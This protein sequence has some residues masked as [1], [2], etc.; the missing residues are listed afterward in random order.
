[1]RFLGQQV[2]RRI[3]QFFPDICAAITPLVERFGNFYLERAELQW[4]IG[5]NGPFCEL[6]LRC[7]FLS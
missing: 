7:Q 5:G 4:D 6:I 2:D 3:R 1:M